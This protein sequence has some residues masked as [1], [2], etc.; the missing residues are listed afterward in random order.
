MAP[1]SGIA[2]DDTYFP[3]KN[4]RDYI[5]SDF[6]RNNDNF[7][8][9]SELSRANLLVL[10]SSQYPVADLHGLEYFTK[11]TEIGIYNQPL[12]KLDVSPFSKLRELTVSKSINELI[13][14]ENH[15]LDFIDCSDNELTSLDVHTLNYLFDFYCN[16][17]Q[18]TNII[19]G[20]HPRLEAIHCDNNQLSSLSLSQCS[21]L[22]TLECNGNYLTGLDI[23]NNL[24]LYYLAVS[25]NQL[26][27]LDLSHNLELDMLKCSN[28]HLTSLDLSKNLRLQHYYF[29]GEH[30]TYNIEVDRDTLEFD[31]S[32]LPGNFIPARAS[33]WVGASVSGM[34][35]KLDPSMPATVTY[36][37]DADLDREGFI[38]DVTLLVTYVP[39]DILIPCPYGAVICPTQPAYQTIPLTPVPVQQVPA[40]NIQGQVAQLP[41]TGEQESKAVA[42]SS[43]LLLS[44][45][46]FFII[47]RRK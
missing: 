17:N 30:Q 11:L 10:D 1:S 39:E 34:T 37:Y 35:L 2:I 26:T 12:S 36:N 8:S 45:G 20:E 21:L 27:E 6:D 42:I 13:F 19:L 31:L 32:S 25:N 16:N 29:K 46:A 9:Q 47:S 41:K 33:G 43:L 44:L 15:S 4:F 5:K 7:I 3:D 18:L 28:N 40:D 22:H 38:M 23:S 24:E 14:G